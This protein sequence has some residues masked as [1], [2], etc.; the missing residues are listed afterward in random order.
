M[1]AAWPLR[2]RLEGADR[3]RAQLDAVRGQVPGLLQRSMGAARGAHSIQLE[4]FT[5]YAESAMLNSNVRCCMK[6]LAA[7]PVL[8]LGQTPIG[9]NAKCAPRLRGNCL[10]SPNL[11]V[12]LAD[13]CAS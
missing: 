4:P 12:L 2:R 9:Q 5:S 13:R 6:S 1:L 10:T 7:C 3:V 8:Q 11:S